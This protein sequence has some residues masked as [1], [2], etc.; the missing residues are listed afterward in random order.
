M[1][2]CWLHHINFCYFTLLFLILTSVQNAACQDSAQSYVGCA[3]MNKEK[4][5][6]FI[7]YERET[8]E[9][10]AKGQKIKQVLLR[11][12]NNS[13]CDFEVET[14]DVSEDRTLFK[15]ELIK[16]PNGDVITTYVQNPSE[17]ALLPIYYDI[18]ETQKKWWKPANYDSYR[19]LANGYSIPPG[20]SVIF[21]IDEKYFRKKISISIPFNYIWEDNSKLRGLRTTS[22]RVF[23]FYEFP[24]G[25]YK[26]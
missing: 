15:E 6:I 14:T 13:N 25:Y 12:H 18:Q 7:S 21:P 20:R 5:S 16:Q 11:L 9:Q 4:P 3:Y 26:D 19:D 17:G 8:S 22:H 24:Q 23:Y 2:S 10:N 1:N